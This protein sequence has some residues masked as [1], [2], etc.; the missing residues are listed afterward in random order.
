MLVE[1]IG[2]TSYLDYGL[3]GYNGRDSIIKLDGIKLIR[4][5]LD[6]REFAKVG[7]EVRFSPNYKWRHIDNFMAKIEA[8]EIVPIFSLHGPIGEQ[9]IQTGN[10]VKVNPIDDDLDWEVPENWFE[11]ARV[12]KAFVAKYG[13]RVKYQDGNEVN[14]PKEWSK[15]LRTMTP[16]AYAARLYAFYFAA[17]EV[18]SE[19]ELITGSILDASADWFEEVMTHFKKFCEERGKEVP[20]DFSLSW[21]IYSREG[22]FQQERVTDD[23]GASYESVD[24]RSLGQAI[25]DVVV[26]WSLE[27]H[28]CTETGWSAHIDKSYYLERVQ[29]EED[30]NNFDN[31]VGYDY[32]KDRWNIFWYIFEDLGLRDRVAADPLRKV[33][34]FHEAINSMP[35]NYFLDKS[36][37]AVP[38]QEDMTQLDSQA[39]VTLRAAL[40]LG[41]LPNFKGITFWHC[42]NNYDGG[43]F[44][45]G[46]MSWK[47]DPGFED[48]T[49]KPVY[50]LLTYFIQKY[51]GYDIVNYKQNKLKNEYYVTL[52]SPTGEEVKFAWSDKVSSGELIPRALELL[53]VPVIKPSLPNPLF[54]KAIVRQIGIGSETINL[55]PP[56]ILY[57]SFE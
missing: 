29:T 33:E 10:A 14:F 39:E 43:A 7:E 25:D 40:I 27:G 36:A 24:V 13:K 17:R 49:T 45:N 16:K 54:T 53:D 2:M 21:H 30:Y 52:I 34:L 18:D 11:Y 41:S 44:K 38:I 19:V 4:F 56:I 48:W 8:L 47:R 6:L 32:N 35:D 57:G 9:K 12:V 51:K 55:D 28:Y 5:F 1:N 42:A 20:T 3:G 37:N 50:S 15:S 31:Q 26:K 22:S 46:G 23:T